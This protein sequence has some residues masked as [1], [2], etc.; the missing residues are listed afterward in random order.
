LL[1]SMPEI[2]GPMADGTGRRELMIPFGA[3][4]YVLRY[5]I[6]DAGAVVVIRAWHS[7]EDRRSPISE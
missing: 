7:R 2:G 5:R 3:A 6:D 4:G 1:K